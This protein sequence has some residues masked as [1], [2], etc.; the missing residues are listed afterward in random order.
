MMI[1]AN[2]DADPFQTKTAPNY[3]TFKVSATGIPTLNPGSTFPL[4]AG[5]S[6][7]H[8]LVPNNAPSYLFGIQYF[9][10]N[11]STYK[12]SRTGILTTT[13]SVNTRG[14]NVGGVLNPVA[15]KLYVT[16]PNVDRLT[17]MSYDTTFNL[18]T[19]KTLSSPGNAP[20]WAT[21]NKAGT[22]LYTGET[23]SGSVTVY[24]I[25]NPSSPVQLQ[26]L[27]L[28][29][30]MPFATHTHLDTTEKFLYVLDRQG[31]LHV[32]DVAADGTVAENRSPFNLGLPVGTVALN[33]SVLSK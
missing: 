30:T 13:S 33:V 32:L 5:S 29:G 1:V 2:K 16:V 9:G 10:K 21:T 26:H 19:G 6:P 27:V 23:L 17:V 11:V 18:A 28:L 15:R 12:I 8:L 14:D 3:T 24:D 7:S 20:C 22:R 25:T 31:V 4:P